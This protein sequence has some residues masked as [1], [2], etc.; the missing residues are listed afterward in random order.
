MSSFV[1]TESFIN[2]VKFVCLFT[3]S[4][5]VDTRLSPDGTRRNRLIISLSTSH[6]DQHED[7]VLSIQVGEIKLVKRR[8]ISC[9]FRVG[10]DTDIK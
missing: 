1:Q 8:Q 6:H 3:R 7:N 9:L 10:I 5:R 2:L 4:V